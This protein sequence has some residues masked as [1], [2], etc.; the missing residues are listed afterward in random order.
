MLHTILIGPDGASR[1]AFGLTSTSPLCPTRFA[2]ANSKS[3]VWRFVELFV[4]P[5]SRPNAFPCKVKAAALGSN[6]KVSISAIRRSLL[7]V[8][9]LLPWNVSRSPFCGAVPACQFIPSPQLFVVPLPTQTSC[10]HPEIENVVRETRI[11]NLIGSFIRQAD[12]F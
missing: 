4:M 3:N 7:L 9:L 1:V 12:P 11:R 6:V 8:V 5:V 2:F 10:A